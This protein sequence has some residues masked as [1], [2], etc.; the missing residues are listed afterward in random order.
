[1]KTFIIGDIH[2]SFAQLNM[3]MN[4][5]KPDPE[6]DMLIFLGDLFDRGNDSWE[7]F[8]KVKELADL[9][10][11][12]FVLLRGNHEDYL[13]RKKL[14]FFEKRM[15]KQV[16]RDTT[17]QSFQRH[18]ERMEDTIP[19]LN[20][21]VTLYYKGDR[22]QCVHAG[23]KKEILEENSVELLV[24]D[25][26]VVM[27]NSYEGPLTIVGHIALSRPA[28][29]TGDRHTVKPLEYGVKKPLPDRGIICIDTGCG[30]GGM[31]SAMVIEGDEFT[32]M[33]SR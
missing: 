2:G 15:W 23:V 31:L 5:L 10:G 32:M 4:R 21:H 1:M 30:K 19:W 24:H 26:S 12:R 22:F 13:L 11:E 27:R 16:G 28:W 25:H 17:V 9:F 7:V 3:M 20:E 6:T 18:G 8:Q 29:F 14:S 33:R